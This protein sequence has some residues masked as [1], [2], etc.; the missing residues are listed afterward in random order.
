L[1]PP[2]ASILWGV[3]IVITTLLVY[4]SRELVLLLFVSAALAYLLSPLVRMAESAAIRRELAVTGLFITLVVTLLLAAYFLVPRLR[5]EVSTRPPSPSGSMRPSTRS[6]RRL[7]LT[8]Q[9]LAVC[10][11]SARLDMTG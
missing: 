9:P 4:L 6:N 5:A 2:P 7:P 10:S 1:T 11:P 3:A 8:I